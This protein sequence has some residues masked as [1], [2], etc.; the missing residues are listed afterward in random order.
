MNTITRK[1]KAYRLKR[2]TEVDEKG[3][4]EQDY[5]ILR[6]LQQGH[7]QTTIGLEIHLSTT[8]VQYRIKDMLLKFECVN[9]TQLIYKLTK[10]GAL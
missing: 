5:Q 1:R 3:L 4:A 10:Q 2:H 9:A 6:L 8:A 7:T